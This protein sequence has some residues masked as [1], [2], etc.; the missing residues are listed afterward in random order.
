MTTL[1]SDLDVARQL[2]SVR[3]AVIDATHH[4]RSPKRSTR[5]RTTRNL[6]IAAA[7]IAALT[8][9]AIIVLQDPPDIIETHVTCYHT[10]S[11]SEE[12]QYLAGDPGSPDDAVKLC[13]WW[14]SNNGWFDEG[15]PELWDPV[16]GDYPVP[17][18][19][20]CTSPTGTVAVFPNEGEPMSDTDFCGA[21]GLADWDSD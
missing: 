6:I 7:A 2:M 13:A 3:S 10:A 20:A 16:R 15:N 17:P 18:L 1:P 19:V 14:W 5:Y 21:L 8:A 9:G 12:P 4:V 11:L